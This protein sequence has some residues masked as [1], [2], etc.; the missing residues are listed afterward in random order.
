MNKPQEKVKN[1]IKNKIH[2][3]YMDKFG[4]PNDLV[5]QFFQNEG[6]IWSKSIK[7]YDTNRFERTKKLENNYN[8]IAD[9][10]LKDDNTIIIDFDYYGNFEMTIKNAKKLFY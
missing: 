7:T 4:K 6:I 10:K 2:E 3:I 9:I 1:K 8:T 5:I